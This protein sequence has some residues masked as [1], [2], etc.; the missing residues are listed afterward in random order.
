MSKEA[1]TLALED[2]LSREMPAG[3]VIGDPKWW[4]GKIANVIAKQENGENQDD[5]CQSYWEKLARKR[6][7]EILELRE[8]LKQEQPIKD[9]VVNA[10]YR[11]MWKQQVEMNQQLTAALSAQPAK[12]EQGEPVISKDAYDGA[13]EDLAIWKKRALE[14]EELNRKFIAEINGPTF[15]GEPA[16]PK[17]EQGEPVAER[18]EAMHADGNVWITTLAAAAL[19]RNTKPQPA[20]KPLTDEQILADETLR[21][22][23][24]MNGGAGPVSKKGRAVIDAIEAAH[25]IK[26]NT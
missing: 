17:Q 4:A 18:F 26:E 12:Q 22:H 13:R 20:Q 6:H 25:G 1:M 23:F 21:Y 5:S 3:T 14:A 9:V 24:G 2:Y 16:Q 7:A 19:V 15:M 11:E 8:K 10:D